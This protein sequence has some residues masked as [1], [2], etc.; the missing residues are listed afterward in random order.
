MALSCLPCFAAPR[1]QTKIVSMFLGNIY[2]NY[3]KV[4]LSLCFWVLLQKK[5]AA[6]TNQRRQTRV[7]SKIEKWSISWLVNFDDDSR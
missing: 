7:L 6:Q 5:Q 4:N 3:R 1:A 2:I